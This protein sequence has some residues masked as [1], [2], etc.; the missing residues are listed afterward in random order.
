MK[1]EATILNSIKPGLSFDEYFDS[2]NI[3]EK[4][5]MIDE[6]KEVKDYFTKNMP[7]NIFL[8]FFC[9]FCSIVS[10]IWIQETWFIYYV[11]FLNLIP[12]YFL[13]SL[14]YN[15]SVYSQLVKKYEKRLSE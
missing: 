7:R 11:L 8:V 9:Y 14:L 6:L 2:L 13:Y 12:S 5:E 3:F 1:K 15:F 4:R 10:Y